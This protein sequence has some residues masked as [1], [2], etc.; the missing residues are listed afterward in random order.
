MA[1]SHV[2]AVTELIQKNDGSGIVCCAGFSVTSTDDVTSTNITTSGSVMLPD[3]APESMI[4]YANLT[5]A[6]VLAWINGK[7]GINSGNY[8]ANNSAWIDSVDNPPAPAT[9][10]DPMPW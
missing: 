5:E 8:E 4:P 2:W 9:K 3:P 1:V 7:L 6:T 10:V